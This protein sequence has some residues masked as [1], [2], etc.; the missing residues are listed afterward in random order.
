[1]G[2]KKVARRRTPA[3]APCPECGRAFSRNDSLS[4]HLKTHLNSAEQRPFHRIINEKFRA[5]NRCRQSKI[6]C[7]GSLPCSRCEQLNEECSYK[8]KFDDSSL[9]RINTSSTVSMSVSERPQTAT[10]TPSSPSQLSQNERQSTEHITRDEAECIP[11]ETKDGLPVAVSSTPK[12]TAAMLRLALSSSPEAQAVL[13]NEGKDFSVIPS[14]YVS[15]TFHILDPYSYRLPSIADSREAPTPNS[16]AFALCK[17]PVLQFLS[18]FLDKEFGTGLAC[19]LLDTYFSS[20]FLSRMHPTCHHIH[21]F[22]LRK[23]DVLDPIQPRQTHPALLGSML[24]VA[25]FSG[26]WF[27]DQGIR[28]FHCA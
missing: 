24:F 2:L 4:R 12:S 22:I 14:T 25:A 19:D 23:M 17:Y 1:M 20:A 27:L 10:S 11:S 18:P 5:C 6:R 15:P 7:T 26:K 13:F 21:N 16:Q 9:S 3:S 28:I 8:P